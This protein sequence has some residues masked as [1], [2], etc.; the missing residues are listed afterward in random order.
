[1]KEIMSIWLQLGFFVSKKVYES[2]QLDS[3]HTFP[4]CFVL[5]SFFCFVVFLLILYK[6]QNYWKLSIECWSLLKDY[7]IILI[8]IFFYSC[9]KD[10]LFLKSENL[11]FWYILFQYYKNEFSPELESIIEINWNFLSYIILKNNNL[12]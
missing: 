10:F 1:M 12:K 3:R 6:S 5:S 4:Y 2:L 11:E 7:F 8:S 9:E